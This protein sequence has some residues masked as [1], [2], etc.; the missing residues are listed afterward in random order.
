[1]TERRFAPPWVI[2]EHNDAC[3]IVRDH[4]DEPQ[5]GTYRPD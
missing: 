3:F 2:E 5:G 1:M 4:A